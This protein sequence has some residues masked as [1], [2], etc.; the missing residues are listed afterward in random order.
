M[1]GEF[2]A[3]PSVEARSAAAASRDW[4]GL[5]G[6]GC[7]ISEIAELADAQGT[8]LREVADAL[9]ISKLEILWSVLA[10][11]REDIALLTIWP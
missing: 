10:K 8:P 7:S 9:G 2:T 4:Q 3:R 6:A 1:S 11:Q 5:R